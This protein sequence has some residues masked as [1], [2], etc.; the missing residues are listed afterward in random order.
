MK[1][2]RRL[3]IYIPPPAPRDRGGVCAD[4]SRLNGSTRGQM[5]TQHLTSV[6]FQRV[7]SGTSLGVTMSTEI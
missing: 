3:Y 1:C 5:L 7:T 2:T 6:C 4:P